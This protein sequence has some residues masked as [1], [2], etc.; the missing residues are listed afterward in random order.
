MAKLKRFITLLTVFIIVLMC[1]GCSKNQAEFDT[2]LINNGAIELYDTVELDLPDINS[3]VEIKSS[4]TDVLQVIGNSVFGKKE[5]FSNY[6]YLKSLP[7]LR[8][9]GRC[10]GALTLLRYQLSASA[11]LRLAM[12]SYWALIS[13]TMQSMFRSRLLSI[14]TMTEVSEMLA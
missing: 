14:L 9:G 1:V 4:N 6:I 5:G 2:V 11:R 7:L 13:A 10:P 12:S 8:L 3:E